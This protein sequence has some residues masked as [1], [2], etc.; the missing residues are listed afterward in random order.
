MKIINL[1]ILAS[2]ALVIV[3]LA[4]DFH[5]RETFHG[6]GVAAGAAPVS[7]CHSADSVK[8]CNGNLAG[9]RNI[10][11]VFID[12]QWQ[13]HSCIYGDSPCAPV[14]PVYDDPI[15]LKDIYR[16]DHNVCAC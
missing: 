4:Q 15:P 2:V 14:D 3:L 5:S 16:V 1:V 10:H 7:G 8:V 6:F 12:D 13:G 9:Y 11:P